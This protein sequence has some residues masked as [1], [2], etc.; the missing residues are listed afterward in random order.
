MYD[1]LKNMVDLLHSH[2][3]YYKTLNYVFLQKKINLNKK[4][5][6]SHCVPHTVGRTQ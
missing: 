4:C 2:I 5:E 6:Q 3:A 1:V